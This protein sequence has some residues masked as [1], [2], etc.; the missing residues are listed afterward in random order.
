VT[1]IETWLVLKPADRP[2]K[3]FVVTGSDAAMGRA[4]WH[5]WHE[6]D[7]LQLPAVSMEDRLTR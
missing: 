7:T 5:V 3:H 2:L 6:A 4:D 1:A